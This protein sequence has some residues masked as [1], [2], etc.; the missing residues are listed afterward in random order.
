MSIRNI[1]Q[2][3]FGTPKLAR[4]TILTILIIFALIFIGSNLDYIAALIKCAIDKLLIPVLVVA[5]TIYGIKYM[6]FGP[7]K[8]AKK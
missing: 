3:F 8:S 4:G 1:Y 2:G 6:I 7:K 5:I